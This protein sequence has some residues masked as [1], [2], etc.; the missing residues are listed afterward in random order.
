MKESDLEQMDRIPEDEVRIVC[1]LWTAII[2]VDLKER[3]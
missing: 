3:D 1:D 2:E